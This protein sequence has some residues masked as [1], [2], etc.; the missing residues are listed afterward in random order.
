MSNV[1]PFPLKAQR[2]IIDQTAGV[3]FIHL[4][5]LE[6]LGC[7]LAHEPWIEPGPATPDPAA[8]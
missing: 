8:A 6:S 7:E 1:S 4:V 5:L 3:L 2:R